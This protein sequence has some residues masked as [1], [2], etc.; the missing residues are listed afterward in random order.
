MV[1]KIRKAIR[2]ADVDP[3]ATLWHRARAGGAVF[4]VLLLVSL[5]HA[6]GM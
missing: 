5:V 6:A 2:K 1:E 3:V 4:V